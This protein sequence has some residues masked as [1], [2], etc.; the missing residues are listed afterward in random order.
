MWKIKSFIS[1]AILAGLA[2]CTIFSRQQEIR[3]M[4]VVKLGIPSSGIIDGVEYE[5]VVPIN[6]V[7]EIEKDDESGNC[8]AL[9][10]VPKEKSTVHGLEYI[11]DDLNFCSIEAYN[12]EYAAIG[13]YEENMI[14]GSDKQIRAGQTVIISK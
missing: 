13:R 9:I 1:I 2:V 14:I 4:P 5:Y 3:Q 10:F 8:T 7:D 11:T 12:D 6:V